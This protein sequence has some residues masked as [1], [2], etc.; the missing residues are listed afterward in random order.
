MG[1]IGRLQNVG[2]GKESVRGT[3]VL[4]SY[5][6]DQI[7]LSMDNMVETVLDEQALG[8]IEDSDDMTVSKKWS[9]VT[10][11]SKMK[12]DSLGL[13]LLAALG[14]VSSAVKGGETI[15]Y[16]H[17]YSVLN[18]NQ[19]PSLTIS[20]ENNEGEEIA[21][22]L[23]MLEEL[24]ISGDAEAGYIMVEATFKGK[25]SV[26]ATLTPAHAEE[27]EFLFRNLTFKHATDQAGLTAASAVK[28]RSFSLTIAKNLY[29]EYESG[30]N[31]P[32]DIFNQQFGITG[33]LTLRYE[34]Q[35]YSDFQ[36]NE[37]PRA[38][39]F[40]FVHAD[41]IG[42]S[43]NPQLRIDLHRVRISNYSR[44]L[45]NN[46]INEESFDITALY[47]LADA[48]MITAILTNLIASY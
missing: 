42:T 32:T 41:T 33:S 19:H 3:P 12:T 8:R 36:N 7:E 10:V 37:T 38:M 39:R 28:I 11:K 5:W 22:A 43:S 16:E 46:S 14:S 6:L 15:V 17:T 13:I 40:D 35:T 47:S 25:P 18:T 48:K 30:S 27:R 23:S 44:D 20:A 2:I 29:P 1:Q 45:A 9:E 21:Y 31:S 4:P 34:D 26:S 24:T